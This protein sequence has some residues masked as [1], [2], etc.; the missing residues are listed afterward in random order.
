MN[1]PSPAS[2]AAA[3]AR[4]IA[5]RWS[6]PCGRAAW[7]PR[8]PLRCPRPAWLSRRQAGVPAVLRAELAQQSATSRRLAKALKTVAF[9]PTTLGTAD[10]AVVDVAISLLRCSFLLCI[11]A[12]LELLQH[13]LTRLAS[14]ES[15][16][17]PKTSDA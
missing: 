4:W 11:M 10:C 15:Q 5:T 16:G 1:N 7:W 17:F 6:R 14:D 12:T 3:S 13:L 8:T 2:R 9:A